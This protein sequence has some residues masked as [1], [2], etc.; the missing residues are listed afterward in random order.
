M[1]TLVLRNEAQDGTILEAIFAPERGMNLLSFKKGNTEFLDQTTAHQ[2]K[3][4][5]SGLGALIGP[6]YGNRHPGILPKLSET[7]PWWSHIDKLTAHGHHDPFHMGVSRYAPW[8]GAHVDANHLTARMTGKQ[9]WQG[10]SLSRIEGQ[11]FTLDFHAS[12]TN[13]GLEIHYSVVSDSDSLIGLDY[14]FRLPGGVGTVTSDVQDYY[15]HNKEPV[16]IPNSW[17]Y[18]SNRYLCFDLEQPADFT[19]YPFRNPLE[20]HILLDTAEYRMAIDYSCQSQENSWQLVHPADAH[21]VCIRPLSAKLPYRPSL[22]VSSLI[23]R[24]TPG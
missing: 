10:Q 8:E 18:D 3:K 19:F 22:T 21:F 9:Q 17:K 16:T 24:L 14:H 5:R 2:F 7:T 1:D 20:G 11:N 15:L 23:I 4:T 13:K 12:L 6:H